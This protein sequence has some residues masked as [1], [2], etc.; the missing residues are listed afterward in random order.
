MGFDDISGV[1]FVVVGAVVFITTVALASCFVY[2][3]KHKL[4]H[5]TA[6]MIS[7]VDVHTCECLGY[8]CSQAAV[9]SRTIF[10]SPFL[11]PSLCVSVCVSVCVC[12]FSV[13]RLYILMKFYM[14]I[15]RHH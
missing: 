5:G 6:V 3:R 8:P 13:R 1:W 7:S 15:C 4:C 2:S 9:N 14:G 12:L 10:H 11:S